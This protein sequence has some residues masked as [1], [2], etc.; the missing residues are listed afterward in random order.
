[1]PAPCVCLAGTLL[2]TDRVAART[3]TGNN[4]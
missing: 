4:L 1:M 2:R 3:E